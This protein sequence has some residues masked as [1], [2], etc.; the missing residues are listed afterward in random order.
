MAYGIKVIIPETHVEEIVYV[1]DFLFG[2]ILGI[3]Y[4]I[5]IAPEVFHY[6]IKSGED[7]RIILKDCFFS[8]YRHPL[9]YLQEKALPEQV[10]YLENSYL[11]EKDIPVIYGDNEFRVS[12][13]EKVCGIDI[14]AS[15]FFMLT[16][17]E[18]YVNMRIDKHGRFLGRDSIAFKY[19][20][21]QRPVVNE[22]AEFLWNMLLS[23]S[24]QQE[25]EQHDYQ[26]IFTHDID[27]I[28]YRGTKY[29]ALLG[30]IL[31]RRDWARMKKR[32]NYLFLKN[33]YDTFDFLMDHSERKGC[34]SRFYFMASA[35]IKDV[36]DDSAYWSSGKFKKIVEKIKARGHVIGFHPGYLTYRDGACWRNE[37]LLLE[38]TLG[39]G[40]KE[41]RQHYLR[42]DISKTL[43]YW[44]DN[45]MLVDSTLGYA[46]VDGFRCG[47]GNEF[48]VFDFLQRKS[49]NLRERPLI[50]MDNTIN[51]KVGLNME[52]KQMIYERY[53]D[54]CRKYK[55]ELTLLF[56]NSS[57]D[58]IDWPG[59]T[60]LFNNILNY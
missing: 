55:M 11:P 47:T 3:D 31:K 54:I 35:R 36:Q 23:L 1:V 19:Q 41:G 29:I 44:E 22:Y 16:R 26:L 10:I 2:E 21:L 18:E 34:V 56:H 49:L 53:I 52:E 12:S 8:R 58:E 57:F 37:K 33:P 42:L 24:P 6:T 20:F 48:P 38:Q 50:A 14:F 43:R 9:T 4:E 25:R 46:D 13:N 59:W 45:N 27:K 51:G 15:V 7:K 17:W 40:V 5:E 30:D 32:L 60:V 39:S 28:F